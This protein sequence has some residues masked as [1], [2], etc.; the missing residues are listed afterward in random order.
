MLISLR[1]EKINKARIEGW[2]RTSDDKW[3]CQTKINKK[4]TNSW[5]DD[6]SD[7]E[8]GSKKTEIGDTFFFTWG[9]V[10]EDRLCDDDISGSDSINDSPEEYWDDAFRSSEDEPPDSSTDNTHEEDS[11]SSVFVGNSSEKWRREKTTGRIDGH[12]PSHNCIGNMK[13]I[14][15][16]WHH[17][18]D[19]PETDKIDEDR[20]DDHKLG[21]LSFIHKEEHKKL[22]TTVHKNI[23]QV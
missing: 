9:D 12:E 1:K 19:D 21:F 17:R 18:D 5:S 14:H 6:E 4:W 11:F 13:M 16:F 10:H 2:E 20:R 23:S 3:Y 15:E 8:Y 7:S 22:K